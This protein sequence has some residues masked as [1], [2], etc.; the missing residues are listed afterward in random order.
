MQ[1]LIEQET[2]PIVRPLWLKYGQTSYLGMQHKRAVFPYI[3][4][5]NAATRYRLT[6]PDTHTATLR[7]L[8]YDTRS[9]AT[10]VVR[11]QTFTF[12]NPP[13]RGVFFLD[14]QEENV[15]R[16][17][18]DAFGWDPLPV[19][20]HGE[21]D[22]AQFKSLLNNAPFAYVDLNIITMLVPQK[23]IPLLQDTS[24]S[25]LHTFYKNIIGFYDSFVGLVDDPTMTSVN[26]NIVN[27][28]FFVKADQS[29]TGGVY[30][31]SQWLLQSNDNIDTYLQMIP[32][33]WPVLTALAEAYD[34]INFK[35]SGALWN[36][37]L[38]DRMQYNVMT[39]S[40]RQIG[41]Y[42]FH[43][44]AAVETR[45]N[46]H[47]RNKTDLDLWDDR[48]KLV[49]FSLINERDASVISA[50]NQSFRMRNMNFVPLP[51]HWIWLTSLCKYDLTPL[52][53]LFNVTHAT[54]FRPNYM[55]EIIDTDAI[56]PY[57][58]NT[59]QLISMKPCLYPI[60]RCISNFN[61][62]SDLIK[63][64]VESTFALF[65]PLMLRQTK[66]LVNFVITVEI[67]DLDEVV[68]D[69]FHLYDG[70]LLA[71]K[72]VVS[73]AGVAV[74]QGLSPGVYRVQRPRGRQNFYAACF[75]GFDHHEPYI[76][77]H[78]TTTNVNVRYVKRITSSLQ[79]EEYGFVIDYDLNIM[80]VFFVNGPQR[81]VS[82]NVTNTV[83]RSD[84]ADLVFSI[85]LTLND[86]STVT[87]DIRGTQ[88][89]LNNTTPITPN[90]YEYEQVRRLQLVGHQQ[91]NRLLFFET[92]INF[93]SLPNNTAVFTLA[94]QGVM[95]ETT[96]AA[97]TSNERFFTRLHRQCKWLDNNVGS[98][99]VENDVRDEI[100]MATHNLDTIRYDRYYPDR[101]RI[102]SANYQFLS[103]THVQLIQLSIR[104]L[105]NIATISLHDYTSSFVFGTMGIQV[106]NSLGELVFR[107]V[108]TS[109]ERWV[110]KSVDFP[111]CEN[112]T[113]QFHVPTTKRLLLYKNSKFI[114]D[115][116]DNQPDLYMVVQNGVLIITDGP[117]MFD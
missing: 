57:N 76:V 9:E 97:P 69:A 72:A 113:I 27:K 48:D 86:N 42:V 82:F 95:M 11:S 41:S 92:I 36:G 35:L 55:W 91:V 65:T 60:N 109:D 68:G 3:V 74:V 58:L 47:I 15:A 98:L 62:T 22:E 6:T 116:R 89:T 110:N 34:Y 63:Q 5:E 99:V 93:T 104:L 79:D 13:H 29:G 73:D 103:I 102:T 12:I 78:E 105:E 112:Y 30:Y 52:L 20:V 46:E 32:S 117:S 80:I 100:Y 61:I 14:A 45:L 44:R 39:A 87:F 26:A 71:A 66:T 108:F 114:Q 107:R 8:N 56:I 2:P 101:V 40:E 24:L 28:Q 84:N 21:T 64:Y 50:I 81:R 37:I 106:K 115:L 70:T 54:F 59:L 94:D 7:L 53:V 19:Y 38:A 75:D 25:A 1:L 77:V 23:S 111:V 18:I 10:Y 83:Y 17:E 43:D 4:R 31:T 88:I 33:A 16:V 51:H 96:F 85:V 67:D 49:V 90:W